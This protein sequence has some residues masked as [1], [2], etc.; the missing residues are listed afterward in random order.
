MV[1]GQP[2]RQKKITQPLG[3]EKNLTTSQVKKKSRN[4]QSCKNLGS[5]VALLQG[6]FEKSH[7][8]KANFEGK[9]AVLMQLQKL[10]NNF[11]SLNSITKLMPTS[12]KTLPFN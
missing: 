2:L 8:F 7:D 6:N 9:P 11:L 12:P 3:P 5:V 10:E 4:L 1:T